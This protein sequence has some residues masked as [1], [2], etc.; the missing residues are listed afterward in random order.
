MENKPLIAFL[1]LEL[2]SI[3]VISISILNIVS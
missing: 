2:F 1:T 3:V